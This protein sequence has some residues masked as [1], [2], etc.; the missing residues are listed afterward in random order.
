M[1]IHDWT[2]VSAGT[3]HDFHCRW[4]VKL[5]D[6]L[7]EGLLPPEYYSM[8][9]QM[10]GG[11]GPDVITLQA[12]T[13][14]SGDRPAGATAAVLTAPLNPPRA[15]FKTQ[16]VLDPY[17]AKQRTLV[18]R[19]GS[20][21]RVV[22]MIEI[23]SAGN[24]SNRHALRSFLDNAVTAVVQGIHLVVIDLHPPG[25]RDPQGIHGVL[26][27]ELSEEKYVAPGDKRLTFASYEAGPVPTA[28]VEPAAV[29]DPLP[30]VPLF[31]EP[32]TYISL[33]LEETYQ[34]A[35]RGFPQRWQKILQ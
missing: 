11:L 12:R 33:P 24:K 19:H 23:V 32:E 10:A 25:P 20:D 13:P 26:L 1:P 17:V 6:A 15:R 4:I 27:A 2:R 8:A 29:G 3:F 18:I 5:S 21:D 31:L 30:E 35:W 16:I 22:A 9:E 7:N 34:A 14:P 28:Y